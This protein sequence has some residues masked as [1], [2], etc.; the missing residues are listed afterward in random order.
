MISRGAVDEVIADRRLRI[1]PLQLSTSA[2]TSRWL[3]ASWRCFWHRRRRLRLLSAQHR[4]CTASSDTDS[5][6]QSAIP[7]NA[8]ARVKTRGPAAL[9]SSSARM[10]AGGVKGYFGTTD[11]VLI[12]RKDEDVA[13]FHA[14]ERH[15]WREVYDEEY[16]EAPQEFYPGDRVKVDGDVKVKEIENARGMQ[17]LVTHFE[18]DDGYE[19]CQTCSSSCPV[20]VLLGLRLRTSMA[21]SISTYLCAAVPLSCWSVTAQAHLLQ[22]QT[23]A[24]ACTK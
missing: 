5:H 18:F 23:T 11:V 19:S 21:I 12:E 2:A 16:V 17:G 4:V 22:Q 9:E 1:S 7:P 20:T 14:K 13:V 8:G 3:N 15:R 10:A 24:V 6:P